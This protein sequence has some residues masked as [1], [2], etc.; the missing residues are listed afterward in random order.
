VVQAGEFCPR[1]LIAGICQPIL[2]P[3]I[4][5][6]RLRRIDDEPICEQAIERSVQRPRTHLDCAIADVFD[7]P[8]Q[9]ITMAFAIKE[10]EYKVQR[11]CR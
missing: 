4:V 2:A 7:A 11:G 9:R 8:D 10:G 3:P 6:P 5:F 1:D